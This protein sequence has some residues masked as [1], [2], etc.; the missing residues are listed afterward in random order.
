VANS[1]GVIL[2]ELRE[3]RSEIEIDA[4]PEQVWAVVTAF[5]AYPEWN[6]FIRRISGEL[7]EGA[8]LEVQ[9]QRPGARATTFKP[10]VRAVETNRELRWLGRLLVPGVFDGEHSLLIDPRDGG[11]SRFVQ[12]ERF[13]GFLVGFLKGTLAKTESGFAQMNAALKARV[14]Q[15]SAQ[16]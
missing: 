1:V 14:E 2:R 4:P 6:P 11:R 7:R 5:A 13:N 3:L 8:R 12:S 15:P 10:P 16:G 9:I